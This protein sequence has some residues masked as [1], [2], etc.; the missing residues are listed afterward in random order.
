MKLS[1]KL[2]EM[3]CG[4]RG[5]E[6][7]LE[8]GKYQCMHCPKSTEGLDLYPVTLSASERTELYD[9]LLDCEMRCCGGG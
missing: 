7:V 2:Q 5:H 4:V 8:S 9:Y 6:L 1:D 3:A